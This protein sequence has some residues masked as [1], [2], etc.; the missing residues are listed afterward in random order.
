MISTAV[1]SICQNHPRDPPL[2]TKSLSSL[3]ELIPNHIALICAQPEKIIKVRLSFICRFYFII[4]FYQG[5]HTGALILV[6]LMK[7][8]GKWLPCF[9]WC[10]S[11]NLLVM[12][13]ARCIYVNTSTWS[14]K[15]QAVYNILNYLPSTLCVYVFVC[16]YDIV[17]SPWTLVHCQWCPLNKILNAAGR[18]L[19]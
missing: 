12:V 2:R 11:I 6:A 16:V 5:E 10:W 18:A 3:Q 14:T 19:E 17:S 13:G 9:M 7:M 15:H 8:V 1:Q 4:D